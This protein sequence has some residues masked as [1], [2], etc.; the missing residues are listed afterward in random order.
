MKY[1][2][3][4]SVNGNWAKGAELVN[5][6][7]AK[8]V[9]ETTPTPSQF[10]NKDGSPKVQDVCKIQFDGLPEPLNVSLN[11]ATINGLVDAFGEDSVAWQNQPLIVE[12]EKMRVAG[13]A[14]VAVYFIP[15]GSKRIDDQNGYALIV[16]EG[17][18]PTVKEKP[19]IEDESSF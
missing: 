5:G 8:I 11:K 7:S 13:K 9:S 16:K 17:E 14:V 15:E 4:I 6:N 19:S 12:T 1:Q 18:E 2:K 3:Q 10:K